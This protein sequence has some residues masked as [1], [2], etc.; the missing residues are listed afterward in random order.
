MGYR[1]LPIASR[2]ESY[3]LPSLAVVK[4]LRL[5]HWCVGLLLVARVRASVCRTDDDCNLNGECIVGTGTCHCLA[6]WT[7]ETCGKLALVPAHKGA[8]LHAAD[9]ATSSSWGGA[10]QFD[11]DTGRF[12]MFA[13]EMVNG[14]GINAWESNSRVVRASAANMDS[15]FTVDAVIKPAFGHEPSLARL[16]SAAGGGWLLFSIGNSSSSNPPRLDCQAGYTPHAPPPNGTGGNF[17]RYVPVEIAQASS[18]TGVWSLRATIGNGDFNPA[19]LLFPNGTAAVM[20]RHLARVHMVVGGTWRGPFPFNGSDARCPA[21][22]SGGDAQQRGCR[23]WHLFNSSVD[24]RGL[25]DPFVFTQPAPHKTGSPSGAAAI[26][27]H[28]LFHDHRSFGGHAYSRDGSA[29]TF[30]ATAPYG[31]VVNFTDGSGVALQRRERPHVV[32]DGR[33]FI[34]HLTTGAQPPPRA[35]KSPPEGYQ[36]DYTYTLVQPVQIQPVQIQPAVVSVV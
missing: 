34:T 29:W 12:Q 16:P 2:A 19:P 18:L 30:S 15:A 25:E 31:N 26:T 3:A 28:A 14:C 32:V 24:E 17:K 5:L 11:N 36:N 22:A 7:S 9:G 4:D 1:K 8:G 35:A 10:V 6:A 33:G 27:Y 21:N 23:W 13:A 20:W